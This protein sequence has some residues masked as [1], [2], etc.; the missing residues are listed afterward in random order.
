[1]TRH[2]AN[3]D[4]NWLLGG[5]DPITLQKLNSKAEMLSR[6]DNKYV[7]PRSALQRLVPALA[8]EFDILDISNRRAF[9]YDTRYFDDAEHSAYFQHHQGQRKRF[10]VRMRRY[11]DAEIS[12]LEVKVKAARGRTQ[13]YRLPADG[14][15]DGRL[16]DGSMDFVRQTYSGQYDQPFDYDLRQALDM[17]YRRIT[18]VAKSGGER[19][20]IDTDLRFRT[21]NG[22]RVVGTDVFVVE[23][24][25]ALGRGFA[26][27]VLRQGKQRPISKCSK[28]CIGMAA[29][30]AVDRFNLFQPAMRKLGL[31]ETGAAARQPT[32]NRIDLCKPIPGLAAIK[33]A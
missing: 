19:M 7:V 21:K 2:D 8:T 18:L 1:M 13:K 20:T 22:T 24:K 5:F 11:V 12:F 14:A 4:I 3:L 29:T 6:I 17:R 9:T 28:Y 25:S 10:K 30:G 26:D 27:I 23:A 33:A 32:D 15:L 31:I 16:C